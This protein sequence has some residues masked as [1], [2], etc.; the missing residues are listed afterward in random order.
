MDSYDLHNALD[1]VFLGDYASNAIKDLR[2]LNALYSYYRGDDAT[3]E[4]DKTANQ[5][6][7]L[8]FKTKLLQDANEYPSI[9]HDFKCRFD[10]DMMGQESTN[11]TFSPVI[12]MPKR[13]ISTKIVALINELEEIVKKLDLV[14]L[15]AYVKKKA[16]NAGDFVL[17]K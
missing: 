5:L 16:I 3:E 1:A 8:V 9:S 15:K 17:K 4:L 6:H 2:Y 14:H 7:G 11:H 12:K 13:V 10:D